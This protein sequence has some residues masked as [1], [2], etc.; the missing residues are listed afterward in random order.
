MVFKTIAMLNKI[1][2]VD[3]HKSDDVKLKMVVKERPD[4]ERY[5]INCTE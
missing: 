1:H 4:G 2:S 3:A 5:V